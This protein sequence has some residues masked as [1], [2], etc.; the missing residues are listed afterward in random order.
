MKHEIEYYLDAIPK[1]MTYDYTITC[2]CGTSHQKPN[3]DDFMQT[4]VVGMY[5]HFIRKV[6]CFVC[7]TSVELFM[8]DLSLIK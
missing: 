7:G 1:I 6:P 5:R 2:E 4:H 3:L 8:R